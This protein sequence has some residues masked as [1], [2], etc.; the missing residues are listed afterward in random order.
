VHYVPPGRTGY[1]TTR[2]GFGVMRL[3]MTTIGDKD[4]VDLDHAVD[5][6]QHAFRAGLSYFDV[7]QPHGV[8]AGAIRQDSLSEAAKEGRDASKCTACG[9]CLEKCPQK[10]PSDSEI[11]IEPGLAPE[12]PAQH[13]SFSIAFCAVLSYNVI[14]AQPEAGGMPAGGGAR[15]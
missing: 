9:E 3:P 6:I 15:V 7:S 8:R 4:Y 2:L 10:I 13:L 14:E 1:A 5:V 12:A 11:F